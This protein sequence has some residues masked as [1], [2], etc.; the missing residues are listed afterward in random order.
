MPL[1]RARVAQ[2]FAQIFRLNNPVTHP[3]KR[4]CARH[5]ALSAF[6]GKAHDYRWLSL[7]VGLRLWCTAAQN[8]Q[9]EWGRLLR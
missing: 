1:S 5:R 9:G 7:N 2:L 6:Q 4:V 8:W 3:K